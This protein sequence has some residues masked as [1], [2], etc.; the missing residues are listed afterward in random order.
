LAPERERERTDVHVPNPA[1]YEVLGI[2]Y[3]TEVCPRLERWVNRAEELD[4]S[5]DK[6]I[7]VFSKS[8]SRK[9]LSKSNSN[10]EL[11]V[12]EEPMTY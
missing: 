9:R 7:R 4:G 8:N 5:R 10:R 2:N 3:E 11:G 1:H 6:I 12:T